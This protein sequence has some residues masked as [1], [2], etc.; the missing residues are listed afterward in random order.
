M[1][2]GLF[3]EYDDFS[4]APPPPPRRSYLPE[5]AWGPTTSYTPS[6]SADEIM[7]AHK[8]WLAILKGTLTTFNEH[9]L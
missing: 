7:A 1:T 9:E 5:Q 3:P 8:A 6:H 4:N 2:Q